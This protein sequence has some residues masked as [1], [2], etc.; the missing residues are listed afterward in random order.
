M[1]ILAFLP[2][3]P[4][5]GRA[6]MIRA[7]QAPVAVAGAMFALSAFIQ[8]TLGRLTDGIAWL[9]ALTAVGCYFGHRWVGRMIDRTD[10]AAAR[11]P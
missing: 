1:L 7:F 8:L 5:N 10:D 2:I 6:G 3:R 11:L 4:R 9:T